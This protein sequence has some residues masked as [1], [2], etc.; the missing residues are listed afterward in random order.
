MKALYCDRCGQYY[1]EKMPGY[2]NQAN[3]S[4]LDAETCGPEERM[5]LCE[6]CKKIV[7][8]C[9]HHAKKMK[10]A[11]KK[12]PSPNMILLEYRKGESLES[13]AEK[14]GITREEAK[15]AVDKFR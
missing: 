7:Y 11:Q 1:N 15:K 9:I 6:D 5:D 13:I 12:K 3:I 10:T 4:I 8:E 14:Y 2:I